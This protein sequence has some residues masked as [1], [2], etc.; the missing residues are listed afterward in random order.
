MR[1][2]VVNILVE[3]ENTQEMEANMTEDL[4]SIIKGVDKIIQEQIKR[5][6]QELV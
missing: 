1:E 5:L 6:V 4:G 2:A 3:V